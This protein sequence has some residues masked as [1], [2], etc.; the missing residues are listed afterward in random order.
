MASIVPALLPPRR[1]DAVTEETEDRAGR[2][3]GVHAALKQQSGVVLDRRV[4]VVDV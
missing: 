3:G 2:R 1:T 4:G